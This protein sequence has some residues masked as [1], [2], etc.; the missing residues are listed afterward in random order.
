MVGPTRP[1]EKL[2]QFLGL[3]ICSEMTLIAL[4]KSGY[5]FFLSA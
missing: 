3:D 1:T 5:F 2:I 4:G